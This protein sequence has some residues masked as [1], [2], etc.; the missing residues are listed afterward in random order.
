MFAILINR[1]R[2][3][4]KHGRMCFAVSELLCATLTVFLLL[5]GLH[6]LYPTWD[7]GIYVV[8]MMLHLAIFTSKFGSKQFNRALAVSLLLTF[9][10]TEAWEFGVNVYAY[11]GLFGR[12]V[13]PIIHPL[14]HIYVILCFFLAVK[15]SGFRFTKVNITLL[16]IGILSSFLFFPPFDIIPCKIGVGMYNPQFLILRTITFLSFAS[17]FYFWSDKK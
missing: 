3:D 8:F 12:S 15:I 1:V 5:D 2:L 9:V 6:W 13:I 4:G 7:L 10:L 11:L 17:A 14:N 16:L